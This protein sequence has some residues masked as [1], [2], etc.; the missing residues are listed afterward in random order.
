MESGANKSLY[1]LLAVVVFGIF[2]ALSY[3]MFQDQLKGILAT[4]LDGASERADDIY[5][6]IDEGLVYAI[7]PHDFDNATKGVTSNDFTTGVTAHNFAGTATSGYN[8]TDGT[9]VFDGV[10]DYLDLGMAGALDTTSAT[11]FSWEVYV[12][13]NS[14]VINRI[15]IGNR[16]KA[17]STESANFIKITPN[18]FEVNGYFITNNVPQDQWMHIVVI[19][20]GDRFIYFVNGI[21]YLD[22]KTTPERM[23]LPERPLYI[24]GDASLGHMIEPTAMKL[25][26]ARV[27]DRAL[28]TEEVL[29]NF[30]SLN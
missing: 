9:L 15:I 12:K 21:K 18:Q 17:I 14:Y 19:K 16:Y 1:T 8:E 5:S 25:K 22:S 30:N 28:T 2:L 20:E 23:T 29:S 6:P 13:I 24:G 7:Y 4:V 10:D 11:D 3:F 26:Y 27:Y